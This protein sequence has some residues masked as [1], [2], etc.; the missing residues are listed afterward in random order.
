M[1]IE[2]NKTVMLV[3]PNLKTGGAERMMAYL[4]N[5]LCRY[6]RVVLVLLDR[7]EIA[8][9]IDD[10]IEKHVLDNMYSGL[11]QAGGIE[12][13]E[14]IYSI[15]KALRNIA[16]QAAADVVVCFDDRATWLVWFAFLFG[17]RKIKRV[18]SQRNDP[19]DKSKIKNILFKHIYKHADGVVYQL[20]TV[21]DFYDT[22]N[23]KEI[24]IPNPIT[25]S[26]Y[27][28]S[29]FNSNKIIAAGRFQD[30]KRFDLLIDAFA[31]VIAHR[32]GY[33]LV[34]Y[35]D[36]DER[37]NLEKQINDLGIVEIVSLPGFRRD[38]MKNNRDAFCFVL[39]SDAEGM[40]NTLIEAMASGIPC[41]ATDC[42]P[43]G[44]RYLLNNGENGILVQRGN[45]DEL[46]KGIMQYIDNPNLRIEKA[47]NATEFLEK[48]RPEVID[49][50]WVDF[51]KEVIGERTDEQ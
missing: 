20:D 14:Y 42:S 43:G 16:R 49:N 6:Y 28:A 10:R 1:V 22:N 21:R 36:G 13:M 40:P 17:N 33:E 9:D 46:A 24:V 50:Q 25:Q 31:R 48:M 19:Y 7:A 41:V 3:H 12:K 51:F 15:G 23:G 32:P 38:V 45:A 47:S 39:S 44:A 2:M 30:R 35:G 5:L 18:Y 4:A 8:F 37:E 26:I 27:K 34:I 11:G 29:D